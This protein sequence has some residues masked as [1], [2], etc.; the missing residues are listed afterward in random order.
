VD[1]GKERGTGELFGGAGGGAPLAERVR[2]SELAEFIGQDDLMG[3]GAV[4]RRMIEDDRLSSVIFWGPPGSGKTTL[5]R[6]IASRTGSSFLSYSAVTSGVKEMKDVMVRARELRMTTGRKTILFID[7]VHRFNRAQQDAFLPFV[8][9]GDVVL[10]G[11]TTENPSF[12]VNAALLSRSK[13][14][15]FQPLPDYAIRSIVARAAVQDPAMA[16]L[17][18]DLS[19]GVEEAIVA[20][21]D[22][23]ARR[24]LTA[25]ELSAMMAEPA[26]D[27]RRPLTRELVARALQQKALAH[28]RD[29]EEHYNIISALHKCLRGSDPDAALY[30]LARMLEA[31]EDRRYLLRRMVRFAVEDIG[32]ADPGALAQGVAAWQAFDY[33]GVPEGDLALAHLAVYMAMAPKSNAVY[34]AWGEAVSD[35]RELTALPVPLHVRN[36]PTRLMRELGYGAA[37][38]Y[39]HDFPG[40]LSPQSFFPEGMGE[41]RYYRPTDRGREKEVSRRLAEIRATVQRLR[42]E[43]DTSTLRPFGPS[44]GAGPGSSTGPGPGDKEPKS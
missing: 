18:L 44:T 19:P 10:I 32:Q 23:D 36:A 40:A 33:L 15:V 1:D 34:L 20:W 21:A 30:W 4:L 9:R 14:F 5:A 24:A 28:D 17:A 39:S 26:S 41:R 42:K 37:Y 6:L 29:R 12:E 25:L 38:E 35:V 31:G 8:E 16:A 27:G 43:G 3:E 11:A 22:G 7:E 13:V 2:P